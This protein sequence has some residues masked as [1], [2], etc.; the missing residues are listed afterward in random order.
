[1]GVPVEQQQFSYED[2][3]I[4]FVS[5]KTVIWGTDKSSSSLAVTEL[6]QANN[7]NKG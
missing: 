5:P 4:S 1:M 2:Q 3:G 6:D 7:F